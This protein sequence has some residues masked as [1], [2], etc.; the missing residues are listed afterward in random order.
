MARPG[1]PWWWNERKCW[2][3]TIDG[4][5]KTAPRSIGRK[6]EGRA[7][8]WYEAVRAGGASAADSGTVKSIF[9]SYLQWDR[10]RVASGDRNAKAHA[11]CCIK[12]Q[13][14]CDAPAGVGRFADLDAA[15]VRHDLMDRF[16]ARWKAEGLSPGY[17][18]ELAVLTKTIFAWAA[19]P[20]DGRDRL[21][22][23]S[24]FAGVKPPPAPPPAER[25]ATRG[26]AARWLRWLW[27]S[28]RRDFALLQRCLIHTGARPSEIARAT[29]GEVRWGEG[30]HGM[31]VIVRK[32]WKSARKTGKLRRVYVPE[33]IHRMLRRRS[34]AVDAHLF[35]T[36]R[37]LP[38]TSNNL[39]TTTSRLR[40]EAVEAGVD[41]PKEGPDRLTC[42]R[43]RHTAASTLLMAG[44]PVSTVAELLGTSVQMIERTY[45]HLL[46]G[47][48]AEA[49]AVLARR[50][51]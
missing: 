7:W 42:Y 32:E 44:V 26:E 16:Q 22:P 19:R 34:G 38:W 11:T 13:R 27:R 36:P 23:E 10:R 31:A 17:R 49:A 2:A 18:R 14:L 4:E 40:D 20:V 43:W 35:V 41:L 3:A 50:R 47:H 29:W 24:P 5:R 33:R 21:I 46:S 39:G 51:R 8:A 6:E 30:G 37:G 15:L 9:E 48:L 12:V 45:K 1:K 28:G 25:Y